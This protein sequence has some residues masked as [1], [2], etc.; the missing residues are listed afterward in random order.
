MR[1]LPVAGLLALATIVSGCSAKAY[2][3]LPENTRIAV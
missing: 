1:L 2:I 3:K